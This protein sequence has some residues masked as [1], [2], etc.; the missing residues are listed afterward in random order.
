MIH[1]NL[2]Q[3]FNAYFCDLERVSDSVGSF[4]QTVRLCSVYFCSS[5]ARTA[6]PGGK[7]AGQS[8]VFA[9]TPFC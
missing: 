5:P 2:E 3:F 1:A 8:S 6:V 9:L 4:A 7:W